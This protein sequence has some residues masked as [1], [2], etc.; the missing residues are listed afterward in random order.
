M[1]KPF[2]MKKI[3]IMG[4]TSGIGLRVAE[5]LAQMGWLVGVAG[6][7]EEALADLKNRFPGNVITARIDVTRAGAPKELLKLIGEMGGMDVYF[8][9]AGIGYE[10]NS[11]NLRDELATMETNV[12]GFTRM[13]VTAYRYFRDTGTSGQIAA[14]TSVAG[15]NGIG[16]LAS[17]SSSKRFQQTYMR[18]LNQLATI[19]GVDVRFTDIRPGWIRTPLLDP[20]E[21]YPMTMRLPYAVP[22]VLKALRSRKRV[23]VIDW[24]WNLLVGLWRLIPNALWVKMP[25]QVSTK[26]ASPVQEE[27]N[28][29]EAVADP[30]VAMK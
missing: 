26:T 4:A 30:A 16:R 11:L 28:A 25:V 21:E 29:V 14:I 1:E 15:T 20:M 9:I 13:M 10:N 2:E 18:A 27:V 5:R 12:V 3:V 22:K 19:D 7:K 17:Y 23:A 8:H 6:R 24:R